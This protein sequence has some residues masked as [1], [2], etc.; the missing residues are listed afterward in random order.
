MLEVLSSEPQS[1]GILLRAGWLQAIT[2]LLE[3]RDAL[4]QRWADRAL[5]SLYIAR[6]HMKQ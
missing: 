5:C 4:V 1:G 2:P 3:S 6:E